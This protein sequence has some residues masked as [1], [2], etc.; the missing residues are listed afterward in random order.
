MASDGLSFT[1]ITERTPCGADQNQTARMC[2]L[3]LRN[4]LSIKIHARERQDKG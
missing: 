2:R 1:E 3:I 4:N